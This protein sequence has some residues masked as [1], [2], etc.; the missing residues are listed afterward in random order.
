MTLPDWIIFAC[1]GFVAMCVIANQIMNNW[2]ERRIRDDLAELRRCNADFE[3]ALK[4][5]QLGDIDVAIKVAGK[6]RER[7]GAGE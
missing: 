2:I 4:F 1:V 7:M 3:S 5:F 6:W